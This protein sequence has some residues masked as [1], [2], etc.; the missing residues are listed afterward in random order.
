MTKKSDLTS[1]ASSEGRHIKDS[2]AIIEKVLESFGIMV[3]VAEIKLF[4]M[5]YVYYLDVAIGTHF[6]KLEGVSRELA[7]AL[8][9]PT[10]KVEWKI[11]VPGKSLIGLLIPKPTAEY[12][13]QSEKKMSN[14]WSAQSFKEKLAFGFYL[15]GELNYHIAYSLFNPDKT[16]KN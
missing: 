5:H 11:P 7:M 3:K 13:E 2:A 6:S 1:E 14:L 4:P 9:S 16:N 10:G 15:W 12:L 8:A